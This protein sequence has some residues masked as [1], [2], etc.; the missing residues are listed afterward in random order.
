MSSI[1]DSIENFLVVEN[2]LMGK[3]SICVPCI[4][5]D[6]PRI[7]KSVTFIHCSNF[8]VVFLSHYK[9]KF[10]TRTSMSIIAL[11]EQFLGE[12]FLILFVASQSWWS[13]SS[14]KTSVWNFSRY[15]NSFL[16]VT[17]DHRLN[18]S[19]ECL[20]KTSFSSKNI[21]AGNFVHFVIFIGTLT[22]RYSK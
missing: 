6:S 8:R 22:I 1:K 2:F 17:H 5:V 21:L 7:Q 20:N 12:E 16:F 18:F 13:E 4:R 10:S 14:K 11:L 3:L 9:L 19:Y 15:S